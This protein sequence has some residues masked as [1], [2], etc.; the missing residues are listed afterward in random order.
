MVQL[1]RGICELDFGYNAKKGGYVTLMSDILKLS[2]IGRIRKR[3]D[4]NI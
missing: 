1:K 4:G 2:A 3:D